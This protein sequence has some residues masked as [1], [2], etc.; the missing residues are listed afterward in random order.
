MTIDDDK[1]LMNAFNMYQ[2]SREIRI[3]VDVGYQSTLQLLASNANMDANEN[4]EVDNMGADNVETSGINEESEV[5]N[6]ETCVA[7]FQFEVGNGEIDMG[8][9]DKEDDVYGFSSEDED[10]RGKG[11]GVSDYQSG[12]EGGRSSSDS[13][14][15]DVENM[16]GDIKRKQKS[17]VSDTSEYE[18]EFHVENGGNVT[19]NYVWGCCLR[20]FI[21][22]GML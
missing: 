4:R 9:N 12:N 19:G 13:D 2:S 1:C 20:M 3:F 8:D 7:N 11:D 18:T 14:S 15:D 17:K 22:L 21:F 16:N 10:W 5:G 6:V